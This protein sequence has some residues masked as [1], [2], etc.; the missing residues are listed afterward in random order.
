M[1]AGIPVGDI[2]SD[3]GFM[4]RMTRTLR[5]Q[6]TGLLTNVGGDESRGG[7]WIRWRGVGD[8]CEEEDGE[9]MGI[10]DSAGEGEEMVDVDGEHKRQPKLA[11]AMIEVK[12]YRCA[13]KTGHLAYQ[14]RTA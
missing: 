4:A 13:R 10:A 6:S 5:D 8:D 1:G 9:E 7:C 12:G 14:K 11:N 3:L 2:G